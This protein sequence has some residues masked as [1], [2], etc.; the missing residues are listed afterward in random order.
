MTSKKEKIK[1]STIIYGIVIIFAIYIIIVGLILYFFGMSNPIVARTAKIIPYPVAVV[2]T[3]FIQT[4]ELIRKTDF[5]K[6]LYNEEDFAQSGK[7][8]DF[9]TPEGKKRWKVKEKQLLDKMIEDKVVEVLARKAGIDISLE[10]ASQEVE[11][12]IDQFGDPKEVQDR[13]NKYGWTIEDFE[14]NIVIPSMYR[15]Q[16]V[17]N[18]IETDET[19][20]KALEKIKNA[21]AELN[22]KKDF[23]EVAKNYSEGE[24]AKDG[25]YLGWFD[26]D[27]MLPEISIFAF[28]MEKGSVSDVI[29]S[30]LGYHII[31]IENRRTID[32]ADQLEIRQIFVKTKN[33][34]DW[35]LEKEKDIKI[36]IPA[37]GLYWDKENG[38]IAFSN[39]EFKK[40]EETMLEEDYGDASFNN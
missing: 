9:S 13:L 36:Y 6:A 30:S 15:E 12:T 29:E 17:A 20:K 18:F 14:K 7:R 27:Q 26:K 3:S 4:N 11:R 5:I 31:K 25:G 39:E 32:G 40:I 1:I 19:L 23:S 8:I 21:Q 37:K 10:M 16:L 2:G 22:D 34:S 38:E 24:S 28:S 35:L 33:I